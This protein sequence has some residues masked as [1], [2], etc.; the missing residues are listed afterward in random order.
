ME[1]AVKENTGSPRVLLAGYGA[2]GAVHARSWAQLG[3]AP[4]LT[5][6]DPD[7]AAR[8]RARAAVPQA[9][10]VDDWRAALPHADIVDVATPSDTHLD[11]AIATLDAGCD[12]LIEKPMAMNHAE[13]QRIAARA[14]AAGRIVQVGYVL[15]THPAARR[16]RDIVRDG[17][18]GAPVW[19]DA[20]MMCL[21]RPRR[22]AGVVLND[23]VHVLDLVL[24]VVGRTPDTV[25]ALLVD[26]LGR[27]VEDIASITLGW[28]DGPSA[29]VEASC[30]VAGERPDPY[31]AGGFSRKHV[32]VTGDAGQAVADFMA[33]SL[34][35][36]RCGQRRTADGWWAPESAAPETTAFAAMAP[37]D[38]VAAELAGFLDAVARRRQPE[39]DVDSGVA[40]A[41]VCDAIFTAARER[42]TVE[43]AARGTR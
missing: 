18:V 21:K 35:V 24:W 1:T 9:R 20:Q 8:E 40:M 38:G 12:V 31:V 36:R 13:A 11:V 19:I 17:G 3:F 39:A 23:A 2:F 14:A 43:V 32:A 10:V 6:A 7:P 27:G 42:R 28:H 15:R 25:S 29:R 37:H 30:I 33:D 26:R 5:I 41:A 34:T 4:R 22:D 16:L